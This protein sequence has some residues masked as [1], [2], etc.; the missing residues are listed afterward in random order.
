[1]SEDI[2]NPET[3]EAPKAVRSNPGKKATTEANSQA[4]G[5]KITKFPDGTIKE[6]F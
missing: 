3:K 2:K 1:M 5:P 4:K 6:D